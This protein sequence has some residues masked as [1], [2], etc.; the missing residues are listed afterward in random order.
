MSAG[1]ISGVEARDKQK[2]GSRHRYACCL[3]HGDFLLG[4]L[5]LKMLLPNIDLSSLDYTECRTIH[6]QH[7]YSLKSDPS[8]FVQ[9]SYKST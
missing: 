5:P 7:C 4:V 9:K 2:A 3:L 6:R 8:D 1:F